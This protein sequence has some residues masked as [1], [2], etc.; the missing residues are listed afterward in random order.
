MSVGHCLFYIPGRLTLLSEW[1]QC[2]KHR[3]LRDYSY[4]TI[5]DEVHCT[6]TRKNTVGFF[7]MHC[8]HNGVNVKKHNMIIFTV[9]NGNLRYYSYLTVSDGARCTPTRKTAIG[10]FLM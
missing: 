7:L 2:K 8:Y 5:S 3:N 4:L 9:N 10:F 6:S 1:C